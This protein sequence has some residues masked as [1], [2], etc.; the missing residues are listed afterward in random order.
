MNGP[1]DTS[2]LTT[3]PSHGQTIF[4]PRLSHIPAA[5]KANRTALAQSSVKILTNPLPD[6]RDTSRKELLDIA[7]GVEALR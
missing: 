7:G 4:S 2:A 5:L 3:P 6:F 1:T